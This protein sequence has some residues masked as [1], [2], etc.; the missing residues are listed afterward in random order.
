LGVLVVSELT[1]RDDRVLKNISLGYASGMVKTYAVQSCQIDQRVVCTVNAIVTP[2]GIKNTIVAHSKKM[3]VD[4]NSLYGQFVTQRETIIQRRKVTEYYF[5]KIRTAGLVA[6]IRTVEVLPNPSELA[7]VKIRYSIAWNHKYRDE[8]IKYIKQIEK[9][10]GGDKVRNL[11]YLSYSNRNIK[12]IYEDTQYSTISWA[13]ESGYFFV[14]EAFIVSNDP[15][16]SP[17]IFK[18]LRSQKIEIMIEP[19]GICD[20]FH[21]DENLLIYASRRDQWRE[22]TLQMNPDFLKNVNS[23]SVKMGC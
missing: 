8:L 16:F 23:V 7:L 6:T 15:E 3:N 14:N 12:F 9:D 11:Y 17:M 19:F 10:T 4:G 21:A 18:Y 2:A 5:S 1:V 13:N 22:I 20:D